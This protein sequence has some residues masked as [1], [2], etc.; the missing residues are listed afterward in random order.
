MIHFRF[1]PYLSPLIFFWAGGC[2]QKKSNP[3]PAQ[4]VAGTVDLDRVADEIGVNAK[5]QEYVMA[6]RDR[7]KK[8][9]DEVLVPMQQEFEQLQRE[10]KDALDAIPQAERNKPDWKAPA[11]IVQMYRNLIDKQRQ[12][13]AEGQ[14]GD[15]KLQDYDRKMK[16]DFQVAIQPA[17]S[18]IC[19]SRGVQLLVPRAANLYCQPEADLTNALIAELKANPIAPPAPPPRDP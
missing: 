1:I 12:M 16:Q 19:Q 6:Y 8:R 14:A 11:S 4:I 2:D 18:S 17:L 13:Q 10:L 5:Y 15:A 7:L 9:L 3:P